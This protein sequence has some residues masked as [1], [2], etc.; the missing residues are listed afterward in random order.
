MKVSR[1][2]IVTRGLSNCCPNCGKHSLFK[3]GSLFEMNDRC[4]RCN[5]VFVASQN[6]GFHF[7]AISLNFGV[8]IT[9]VLIPILTLAWTGHLDATRAE[10]ISI[11]GVLLLPFLLYRATCSWSLMNYFLFFPAELPA[12]RAAAE[13]EPDNPSPHGAP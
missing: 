11:A 6:D 3:A 7:R 4:P 13:G 9:A 10:F 8:T 1:S 12:N 2:R 5:F